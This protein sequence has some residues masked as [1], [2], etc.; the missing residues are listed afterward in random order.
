MTQRTGN[1]VYGGLSTAP[2]KA[3][4]IQASPRSNRQHRPHNP[5][6]DLRPISLDRQQSAEPGSKFKGG[7]V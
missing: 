5:K 3:R 4:F 1:F 7:L 2:G 6:T